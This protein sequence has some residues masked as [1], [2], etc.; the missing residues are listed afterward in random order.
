MRDATTNNVSID[1]KYRIFTCNTHEVG[2]TK[3]T[4]VPTGAWMFDGLKEKVEPGAT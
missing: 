1:S 2:Q 4:K 3:V